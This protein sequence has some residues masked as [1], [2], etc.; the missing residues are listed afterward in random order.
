[1]DDE[2]GSSAVANEMIE[3]ET[4]QAS[5]LGAIGGAV[6]SYVGNVY[7]GPV[8]GYIGSIVGTALGNAVGNALFG[9]TDSDP[10][11]WATITFNEETNQFE[12]SEA[13]GADGMDGSMATGLADTILQQLNDPTRGLIAQMTGD[14]GQVANGGY[15]DDMIVG[16]YDGQFVVDG[17]K[18]VTTHQ[19]NYNT[20]PYATG[21]GSSYEYTITEVHG[22]DVG[23]AEA[24]INQATIQLAQSLQVES[25]NEHVQAAILN[26][27]PGGELSELFENVFL[28][29]N[30]KT[31]TE[32]REYI[33]A[34][35][36]KAFLSETFL[37]ENKDNPEEIQAELA[38]VSSVSTIPDMVA[39]YRLCDNQIKEARAEIEEIQERIVAIQKEMPVRSSYNPG[40]DEYKPVPITATKEY[41]I[42]LLK[43]E[44]D[45]HTQSIEDNRN[46]IGELI[47]NNSAE[48]AVNGS[49]GESNFILAVKDWKQIEQEAQNLGLDSI[50]GSIT[51]VTRLNL[52]LENEFD[53]NLEEVEISDL[54]MEL[55]TDGSLDIGFRT[56]GE[57]KETDADK[58]DP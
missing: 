11:S 29:Q 13:W 17:Q 14:D 1:M 4:L 36:V 43:E 54:L 6:G 16:F 19:M 35:R 2:I 51:D 18:V 46:R 49:N 40:D 27:S 38:R 50:D 20:D 15:I 58:P 26:T 21:G 39:E 32:N 53:L 52:L 41:R 34:Q 44:I 48:F 5:T 7:A 3:P 57:E 55:N 33:L 37:E 24:L 8:G 56:G 31:L 9:S 42:T 47:D 10:E 25:G 22:A 12:V 23:S 28:A 30:F 45:D